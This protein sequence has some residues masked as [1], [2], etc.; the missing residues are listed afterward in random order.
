[1]TTLQDC[2]DAAGSLNNPSDPTVLSSTPNPYTPPD[3]CVGDY[4]LTDAQNAAA[5]NEYQEKVAAEN[6]MI[7]GATVNVF[8]LLGIHEQG[9]LIDLTGSGA[10]LGGSGAVNAF[11][12]IAGDWSS[13]QTGLSVLTDPAYIGYD[14]GARVTSFNEPE[15]I[16]ETS[17]LQ[18]ITSFR[19]QQ[20]SN[21]STRALQVRVDRSDGEYFV[22][23]SNIQ[24]TGVGTGLFTQF[25]AGVQARPGLLMLIASSSTTFTVMHTGVT[26]VVLG[27]AT[28]S[29]RF[30]HPICSFLITVGATP[31]VITDTFTIQLELKW[32]RVDV[33]N[34]P[35]TD[36]P[37][38]IRIHQSAPARFWRLVPLSFAGVSSNDSWVI[39][40]LELMDY[41]ATRLD[42]IQDTLFME[43]RDRDYAKQALVVRAAY[44]PF[45]A[46]SD[47]SK[48]GFSIAD[49]YTFTTSYALMIRSLGR[50]IVV[51]DILE[52]PSEVQ[53]D[54]NL[55]PVR[56]FLEVSDVS[57]SAEGF[58]TAWKPVLYR[59]Q[60]SQ[61]IPGQE[62][63]D[64]LGTIDTQKY[65][66]SDATFFDGI[67][68]IE[69]APLTVT[70]ANQKEAE[71]AVPLKGT[72]VRE[73]SSGTNRFGQ[74]GSYDGV[75]PYVEDGL[76]PDGA[77]CEVGFKLPDVGTATDGQ[78]F[79]LEYDP[80][81]K[82]AARLYKFSAVK[83]HW[84]Y[85]ETDRRSVNSSHKPSQR[86]LLTM[87]TRSSLT[88]KSIT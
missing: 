75:Q 56:K 29:V 48:F 85:V 1:M 72:N 13:A 6:L 54:H 14:F 5:A 21:P 25:A 42:D 70:T 23:Y 45:D 87:D 61:L 47:L 3:I 40:K 80:K 30:N 57:W 32:K 38:L 55:R 49:I 11:D 86:K 15:S 67:E 46:I 20:G 35:N 10:P 53:Y 39:Q 8:K 71:E 64:L 65:I 4:N 22:N 12:S 7:S 66:V 74:P 31:F 78:F 24:F 28:V 43:N 69:T 81:L 58:T 33:V 52:L 68:Q 79:R 36:T 19:I 88:K 2:A 51:G 73:V 63:R 50:P 59:F 26:T 17:I 76:P 16:P 34:L 83:N 82:I 37:A 27:T 84:I 9:K 44:Q 41:Q 60:A 18:S 77:P 62:H